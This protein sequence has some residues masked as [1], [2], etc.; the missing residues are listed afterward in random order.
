MHF[1]HPQP[2]P[3]MVDDDNPEWTAEDF[4]KAR[5]ARELLPDQFGAQM[6]ET[7]LKQHGHPKAP[8]P[9]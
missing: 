8:N 1:G 5:S 7:M 6:A 3:E 4:S 2:D 9:D